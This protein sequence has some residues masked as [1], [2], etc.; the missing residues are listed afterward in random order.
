MLRSL[1]VLITFAVTVGCGPTEVTLD[2]AVSDAA[3]GPTGLLTLESDPVVALTFGQEAEVS[4][5]YTEAGRPVAGVEVRFALVGRA[6]SSGVT[7]LSLVTDADGRVHT[8]VVAG[9]TAVVFRL[10]V[11]AERSAPVY[12][13]VSVGDM[14]FGGLVVR[15]VYEG[16]REEA[17]RRVVSVYSGT[18]CDP[19]DGYPRDADRVAVLNADD[20]TQAQWS[21]LAAGLRY[22]VVG[23]VEGPGGAEL[24]SACRDGVE[25][26]ADED[27]LV[28]LTFSDAQLLPAGRYDTELELRPATLAADVIE[29]SLDA[30]VAAVGGAG[31]SLY[32]DAL[33]EE[34]SD[35]GETAAAAALA[36]E[37][38]GGTP[39]T[40]LRMRLDAAGEGPERGLREL[41]ARLV[42]RLDTLRWVGPL[43]LRVTDGALLATWTPDSLEVGPVSVPD[44]PAP[45]VSEP[46]VWTFD[47]APAITLGWDGTDEVTLESLSMSVPVGSLVV[48]AIVAAG[49]GDGAGAAMRE[50]AGCGVLAGWISESPTLGPACDAV[51]AET[52]CTRA[53]DRI[54]EALT[55]A[56]VSSDE[57]RSEVTLEGTLRLLDQNGD[58]TVDAIESR[59]LTGRWLGAS[60]DDA[61]DASLTADRMVD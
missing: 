48:T 24:A 60:A 38:V 51:C 23:R 29:G 26:V 11:A 32:L 3:V 45:F 46:D 16:G 13:D 53:L 6:Q 27:T 21:A 37:R 19:V 50:G 56:L 20:E 41:V 43:E 2:G 22:T 17:A 7:D 44:G 49:M 54:A 42:E 18:E 25:I 5:Q 31:A 10:R 15:A 4:V 34:L 58:L 12:V 36:A 61:I 47:P 33:E 59:D 9:E 30:G 52:A 39:D 35:R 28:D 8:T 55:G 1:L 14:G 40:S 57:A